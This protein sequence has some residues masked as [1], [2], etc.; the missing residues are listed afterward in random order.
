MTLE[1]LALAYEL[2]QAGCCWKRIAQGLGYDP[3]YIK[4]SVHRACR[5]GIG[6][7]LNGFGIDKAPRR[8]KRVVLEAAK[9]YRAAG[10][11]WTKIAGAVLGI[12]NH[13]AGKRLR[14]AVVDATKGGYI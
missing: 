12:A 5:I 14:S 11:S 7:R 4:N 10:H 6:S 2:N 9:R 3:L 1:E 13:S 8:Y